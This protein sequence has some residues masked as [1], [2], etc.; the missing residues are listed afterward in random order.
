M[1]T[2]AENAAARER[3]DRKR[4]QDS[5]LG[6][7]AA[8]FDL[9]ARDNHMKYERPSFIVVTASEAYRIGW[10]QIFGGKNDTGK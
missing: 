8:E 7:Q 4:A 9:S 3:A 1:A 6:A 10:D 5:F 2:Y